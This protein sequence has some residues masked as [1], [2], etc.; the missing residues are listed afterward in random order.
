MTLQ[1]SKHNIISAITGTQKYI[2]VNV[3]SE[4]ADVIS[5]YDLSCLKAPYLDNIPSEF[6]EKGY[7]VNPLEEE[8][9]F[10]MKYI[11]YLE[12]RDNEEMQLFFIPT[13]GCNFTC[14]YCYQSEYPHIKQDIGKDVIDA[15]FNFITHQFSNRKKYI[16]LFGGE[17][18]LP[19]ISHK[20][21]IAYFLNRLKQD[22]LEVAVVT[23]GYSLDG[24]LELFDNTFTREIQITLD[25]TEEIHNQRRKLK[26][27]QGT[28]AQIVKNIDACLEKKIQVNLR[29]VIDKENITYLPDLAA[30]AIEKGWTGNPFFKSQIG[31]N[32][33]LHYCQNG[34]SKLFDRLSLYQALYDTIKRYPHVTRFHKPAFS[35]MKFL[36]ENGN[37]PN[38]LFDACPACKSEW[39]MDFSGN[40]Y[41]CTAT[42]G[43]PEE[44]LGTF[45]P[46][47]KL[48]ESK[49]KTWQ[50]R[51]VLKIEN[52]KDCKVQL[53]C[54]GGCGSI[55]YNQNK[56]IHST[57]C[58]PVADLIGLGASAY[59][60]R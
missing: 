49:I 35:V 43:K 10:R 30:F 55:A 14:S 31:R 46:E 8:M 60:I 39:A 11:D 23:N 59:F 6:I 29:M 16:T 51:D 21:N 9:R 42:V 36:Q 18:L 15:F 54:G 24:Y 25:G 41:P 28:F 26:N 38:P 19:S 37:L 5:D 44:L 50:Q 22:Q 45:Y 13:Y 58:R 40:I 20:E 53:I 33:E 57:D 48:Q 4:N 32:Y 27:S 12:Q 3:L 7:V 1:S 34:Q 56:H 17:P 52:C 47:I 2:I